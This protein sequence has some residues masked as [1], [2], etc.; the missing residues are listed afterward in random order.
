[1]YTF[2]M[3]VKT[4]MCHVIVKN[5]DVK[6]NVWTSTSVASQGWGEWGPYWVTPFR[7]VTPQY[8][9]QLK[10]KIVEG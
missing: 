7:G 6:F 9:I 5:F 4:F 1:M 8:F 10:N 3:Q 2:C